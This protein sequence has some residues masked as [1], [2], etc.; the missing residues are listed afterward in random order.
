[1]KQGAERLGAKFFE[2]QKFLAQVTK[3]PETKSFGG[4][5]KKFAEDQRAPVRRLHKMLRSDEWSG[6][7]F[8]ARDKSAV[9]ASVSKGRGRPCSRRSGADKVGASC[10][11][12]SK[13]G[14]RFRLSL[15]DWTRRRASV[16]AGQSADKREWRRNGASRFRNRASRSDAL[17][18]SIPERSVAEHPYRRNMNL[19]T[20]SRS[21]VAAKL[22]TTVDAT[23]WRHGPVAR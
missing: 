8:C 4:S 21:G 11:C 12:S 5:S 13:V 2:R 23:K 20:G 1:M 3:E 19:A 9:G 10:C 15:A 14:E 6:A 22:E 17:Y 7:V 16:D 18:S